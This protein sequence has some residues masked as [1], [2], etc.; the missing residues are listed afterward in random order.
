[1]SVL[2]PTFAEL[3]AES[4]QIV[5]G[6]VVS[7]QPYRSTTPDGRSLIKTRVT[8]EVDC[9][10]KGSAATTLTLDFLGGRVGTEALAVPGMPQFSVG[11][12]DFLFVEPNHEVICPLIAAGHGRYRVQRDASTGQ[13]FV[14]RQNGQPLTDPARVV[15]SLEAPTVS[16][17][18]P[19]SAPASGPLTPEGFESAIRTAVQQSTAL[20]NA[21]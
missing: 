20:P 11:N 13:R 3:V 4:G 10:L 6:R 19:A 18:S 9:T 1:M 14:A 12:E 17:A 8:W 7:V 5:H 16:P 21:R 15:E 2:P